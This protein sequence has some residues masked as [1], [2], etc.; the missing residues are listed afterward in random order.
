VSLA[1]ILLWVAS[2]TVPMIG[3][4]GSFDENRLLEDSAEGCLEAECEAPV[5]LAPVSPDVSDLEEAASADR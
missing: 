1:A 3:A 2:G 5:S 4:F